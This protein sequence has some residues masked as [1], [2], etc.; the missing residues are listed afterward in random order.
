MDPATLIVAPGFLGGL[1]IALLFVRVSIDTPPP[2][3]S[4]DSS[5]PGSR[6]RLV[7]PAPAAGS[8]VK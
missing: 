7:R 5:V 6:T 8:G 3:V 1:V 2:A 4:D